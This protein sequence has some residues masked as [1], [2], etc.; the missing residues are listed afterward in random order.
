MTIV[1]KDNIIEV[2]RSIS[3]PKT[4]VDIVASG[5]VESAQITSEGEAVIVLCVDPKR[6]VELETI[7]QNAEQKIH[8]LEGVNKANVILTAKSIP[9]PAQKPAP[10]PHGMQKNPALELLANNIIVVASGKGGVGKSTV[11]AN[12]AVALGQAGKK[13]GLLDAD[14]Y[15]PSQPI[16]M[17]ASWYKPDLDK[18]KKIQPVDVHGIQMMSIGFMVDSNKALIW[19]GPMAQS[20]FYQLLRDVAWG[21]KGEPL[22]Y[23]IIDMPPGTG[24]IQLT[25]AQKVDVSG[26]VIVSTPQDIALIDARRA[27]QM[28][29]KTNIP[30]IGLIENMSTHICSNC[31]HEEHIFGHGGA[32]KEALDLGISYLGDVPLH[33][34]VRVQSDGGVPIVL[35]N[36]ESAAA[37]SFMKMAE[38]IIVQ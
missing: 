4:G 19:R 7:R 29:G 5:M 26:A 14:I 31:G 2:L 27:V 34:D 37:Q 13:V 22:D 30:I 21:N 1:N 15:G 6:G 33:M 9:E 10:D 24:D 8:T 28:F 35:S 25:L 20:A 18:T 38:T 36:P 17:G 23:L 16:L 12:L 3:D 11:S 32:Q